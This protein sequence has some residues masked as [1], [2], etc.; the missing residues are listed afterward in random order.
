MSNLQRN[1]GKTRIGELNSTDD[2]SSTEREA[3]REKPVVQE[4]LL[5]LNLTLDRAA[6]DRGAADILNDPSQSGVKPDPVANIPKPIKDLVLRNIADSLPVSIYFPIGS[7]NYLWRGYRVDAQN[8]FIREPLVVLHVE[9]VE[10]H[11][12]PIYE[13]ANRYSLTERER[14]ALRGLSM[15][16]ASKELAQLM[17]ISPNTVKAFL[18]MIMLKM[19]VTSRG[20]VVANLL[21]RATVGG[22]ENGVKKDIAREEKSL[23]RLRAALKSS[24]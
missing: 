3:K 16:L 21:Q 13:V 2:R 19:G 7:Q 22:P 15:G 24:A 11:R 5:L 17:G 18:R 12:D 6:L 20:G 23:D 9:R 8:G 14:E 4:G 1:L 10:A